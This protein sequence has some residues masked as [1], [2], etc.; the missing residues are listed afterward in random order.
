M[1]GLLFPIWSGPAKATRTRGGGGGETLVKVNRK[2]VVS[3]GK[4]V[5]QQQSRESLE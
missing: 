2:V 5:G 1:S 3:I 4:F